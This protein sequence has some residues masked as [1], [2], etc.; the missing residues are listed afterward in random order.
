MVER[1]STRKGSWAWVAR[2]AELIS[3]V[4]ALMIFVI[5]QVAEVDAETY[6]DGLWLTGSL[7]VWLL[8]FFRLLLP[9]RKNAW[10]AVWI[11]LMGTA[12]FATAAYS[13]FYKE[14]PSPQVVFIPAIVVTGLLAG[15]W[16]GVASA[17][18]S[19]IGFIL[20]ATPL[21]QPLGEIRTAFTVGVFLLCGSIAGLLARELRTHYR[22]EQ[23]EHRLATAVRHRL[24]AVLD[25]VDE[26]IVFRDRSG[27]VR[28]LNRRA[29]VLFGIEPDAALGSPAN[30]VLRTIARLTED[31]EGFME[32]FQRLR[33]QPEAELRSQV[34]QIIPSRR[35]LRLY[36]GPA[37]DDSG[38]LVGRIDVYSDV[39]ES[40]RRAAENERLYEEARR[41]AESYQ[42]GLL[43]T[44]APRLPR[45]GMVAHYVAAAG[46]RAVCG[47]LYDFVPLPDGRVAVVMG[48]VI[49]TGPEAVNDAALTRYTLRSFAGQIRDPAKMLQW[50]NAHLRSQSTPERFV[51]LVVGVLDPERATLDYANAGHVPPVV[52]RAATRTVEWLE[53]GDIALAIED[54]V[55][56]K[57]AHIEL[58]PGDM[59]VFYTDG[60]TE[61]PRAGR[62]FG[63]GRFSDLVAE[64]GIGTPGELVQAIRRS[65]DAWVDGDL[66]D[67][68]ALVVL[69]VVPDA[70]LGEPLRELVVP[71]EAARI[72]EVRRFV[73][74]FL[75]DLRA[76]VEA[77]SEVL[78][79]V[80]EAA[81]NAYRH[82]RRASARS[83]M[84]VRCEY[85][86]P[87]LTITVADE[88]PG[89]AP[90]EVDEGLPDPLASG[91]RG[92]F[93]MREL[94]DDVSIVSGPGTTVTLTRRILPLPRAAE[95]PAKRDD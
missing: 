22:G 78:L 42:R 69:Q 85:E 82:G 1:P 29:G 58:H 23:E 33:D 8:V 19:G 46:R 93:L 64:W 77:T 86:H 91:G 44:D 88:G 3:W 92:L 70:V 40:V 5:L 73:G 32:T 15:A 48:D 2:I 16:G 13:V 55:R 72:A 75:A 25:A 67:D 41:T 95:D 49:G 76:P 43:P 84:R 7:A 68:L 50:M 66:R 45:V 83:E 47:D 57:P 80:G 37:F 81:G 71:N 36:S 54:D 18:L 51:R 24:L 10:W 35:Q 56:Y 26:G 9:R 87:M 94:M 65:V 17:I 6:E 14:V 12:V 53:E 34:E 63:Q 39:T 30:D 60:L 31:P 27:V 89:F 59:L 38:S 62:P 20:V 61:A 52:F 21:D 11:P 28:V 79:A 90:D 4:T 74:G